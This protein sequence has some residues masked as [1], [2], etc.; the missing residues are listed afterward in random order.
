MVNY[1]KIYGASCFPVLLSGNLNLASERIELCD[2]WKEEIENYVKIMYENYQDLFN[3]CNSS[4]T[5]YQYEGQTNIELPST[6]NT[7]IVTF[8]YV[9]PSNEIQ[10]F[11]EYFMFGMNDLI[12][13]VGG[14]S[15]LFIGFS[16]YG[17]ISTILG[18]I[19]NK[20]EVA[21]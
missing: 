3:D 21:I 4:C 18:Y 16:F 2:D 11:E 14:H 13:T 15:G 1:S 6:K 17:F 20:F 10:V 12:G 5:L 9:F 7:S 8:N 19:K